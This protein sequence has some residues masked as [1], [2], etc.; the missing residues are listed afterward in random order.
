MKKTAL[1]EITES[2]FIKDNKELIKTVD[3][4]QTLGFL[5]SIDDFGSGYSALNLLKD[6]PVNTIKIDKEFLQV[7]SNTVRGKKVL[8]NIIAMCRD[9]KLDVVT[10]GIENKEQADFIVSCGCQIAQGFLFSKAVCEEEFRKFADEYLTNPIECFNFSFNGTLKTND[11][12]MEGK[13]VGPESLTYG[14]GIFEKSKSVFFPGGTTSTNVVEI[15]QNAIVNDSYTIS[16]WI[17]PKENHRWSAAL[18]VKYESGFASIVPLAFEGN[19]DFR[20]RDS[21]EVDGWYDIGG[22]QLREN[23]WAHFAVTYNAKTEKAV[24]FINGEV[25]DYRENV[26]TNRYAKLI[27]VGGD[28]FQSSFIGNICEVVIYNEPKD[29]KF[30]QELHQKYVTRPDFIA[31]KIDPEG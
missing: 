5:V 14:E 10:E 19:S 13:W 29:Y 8:K 24:A 20:I 3:A 2:V 31:L 7:S 9:L 17:R 18:Y 21:R 28:V 4:L 26:P 23:E 22:C 30:V 12:G 25:V 6:I 16:M 1:I 11:G 27:M 15:P